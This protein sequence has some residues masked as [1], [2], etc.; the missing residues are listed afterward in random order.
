MKVDCGALHHFVCRYLYTLFELLYF[1]FFYQEHTVFLHCNAFSP[2]S[3]MDS[4]FDVKLIDAILHNVS[5][6]FSS[7]ER[8]PSV[9]RGG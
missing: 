2:H 6:S 5:S 4:G 1:F 7:E 8:K 3:H 9:G